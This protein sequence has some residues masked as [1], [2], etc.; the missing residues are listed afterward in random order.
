M[1]R[2]HH[3]AS[4]RGPNALIGTVGHP[5]ADLCNLISVSADLSQSWKDDAVTHGTDPNS[6]NQPWTISDATP[7]W[8]RVHADRAFLDPSNSESEA[9]KYP[10]L[11]TRE[12]AVKWY[13]EETGFD[14]SDQELTWAASFAL[15]RDSI[16]FQGIAARYATRQATSESAKKYG[17]ERVCPSRFTRLIVAEC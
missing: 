14:L 4:K 8:P 11:P 9:S 16:I 5:L 3:C 17:D 10:G 7:S 13:C 6:R 15:F 12:Q 1:R 2:S